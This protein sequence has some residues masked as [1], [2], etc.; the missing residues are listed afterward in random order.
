MQGR[1]LS[2]TQSEWYLNTALITSL[3]LKIFEVFHPFP[4]TYRRNSKVLRRPF[5]ALHSLILCLTF[6]FITSHSLTFSPQLPASYFLKILCT[7]SSASFIHAAP[8][9]WNEIPL[10]LPRPQHHLLL[11]EA[12]SPA[13]HW[14]LCPLMCVSIAGRLSPKLLSAWDCPWVSLSHLSASSL[15]TGTVFALRL[16]KINNV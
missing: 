13:L 12:P 4:S 7:L 5:K 1:C 3:L 14:V 10:L 16:L 2:S 11:L 9:M 6:S 15:R 8:S